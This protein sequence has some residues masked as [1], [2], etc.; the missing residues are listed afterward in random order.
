M[1]DFNILLFDDFETLDAFGPAE[2]IGQLPKHYKLKYFSID[3]GI[4]TSSHNLRI[5]TLSLRNSSTN[6]ILLIPGGI[7][8]RRLVQDANFLQEIRKAAM[9]S[10]YV[11]TVC[12][13]SA[14]LAKAGL[15]KNRM[16]TTNKIAFDWVE[17]LDKDVNW[18]RKARWTNDEK[19]YTSSGVSAGIDMTLGFI[20]DIHGPQVA[21]NIAVNIEYIWNR[22]KDNDPFKI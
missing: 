8:T 1:V 15:L 13:G 3:G 17:S 20:S 4:V 2:V 22:E 16:A 5:D 14:I 6:S 21:E 18:K 19:F 11:L 9:E 7:G 10:A 12:T